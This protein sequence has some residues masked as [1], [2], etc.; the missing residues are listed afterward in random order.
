MK[1][2]IKV[3]IAEYKISRHPNR[4]MTLGLGSCIG[5]CIYD[6]FAGGSGLGGL[7]HIMLPDSSL[8][9]NGIKTGKF[10]DLAIPEMVGELQA[11]GADIRKLAAKIA[12]GANMFQFPDRNL[13]LDIGGRNILAVRSALRQLRIPLLAEETGGNSGR[14]LILDLEDRTVKVVTMGRQTKTI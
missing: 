8:F 4:V 9:K 13:N 5:I 3:G 11:A 2:D 1:E 14:T 6:R 7:A 10:A 12:G